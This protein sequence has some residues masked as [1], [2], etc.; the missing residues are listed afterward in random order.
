[1]FSQSHILIFEGVWL[2]RLS[3]ELEFT[4]SAAARDQASVTSQLELLHEAGIAIAI[5]D[6]GTGYSNVSYIQQLPVSVLKID[7][8]FVSDLATSEKNAKLVRSMI[9]MA[10]DLAGPIHRGM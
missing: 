7:R 5:D 3:T 8:F 9:A 2:G 4:E 10:R 1:M 6:F